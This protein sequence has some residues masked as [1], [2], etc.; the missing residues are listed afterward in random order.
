[1]LAHPQSPALHAAACW[2]ARSRLSPSL[3]SWV[4]I[5]LRIRAGVESVHRAELTCVRLKFHGLGSQLQLGHEQAEQRAQCAVLGKSCMLR[6]CPL[7]R[8]QPA[9]Q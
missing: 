2:Q 3:E 7:S 1:M 8:L 4:G 9:Y 6:G 5:K